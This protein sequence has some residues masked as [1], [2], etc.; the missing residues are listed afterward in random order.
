[1]FGYSTDRTVGYDA[2]RATVYTSAGDPDV[3]KLVERPV[4]LAGPGDVVVR[5]E[6]S[7]VNPTDWKSRRGGSPSGSDWAEVVPHHDGSGIVQALGAGVE[8]LSVGQRVW[9]YEATWQ[10]A[11]GT[12]QEYVALPAGRV[13]PLPAEASF[14][15]GA[16]LGVPALTAH[17]CLTVALD[18]PRQ[19]RPGALDGRTVLVAGGAGAVGHMAVELARWA[20]ARVIATASEP[21]KRHSA[22]LAGADVVIDYRCTDA[23]D[24]I[25]AA[26]PEGVD[27]VVEVAAS[28]N[29][30]LD[31]GVIR[32]GGVV[33]VYGN[34]GGDTLTLELRE[35]MRACV[36]F[37]FVMVFGA[38]PAAKAA[39]VEDVCAAVAAGALRIGEQAGLP[40]HT[41]PLEAIAEAHA[42]VES[43][44]AGK[45]LV[46]V[47][48][49]V[50]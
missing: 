10:R 23:G 48:A 31:L 45:V 19:L 37:Q 27:I 24:Q 16:S 11:G 6:L 46:Q 7:G 13:V 41:F 22:A 20:G 15:L 8:T 35:A 32:R 33:S 12:A 42:A 29:C 17:R 34:N 2:M 38:P 14:E 9:M 47:P 18:G 40:V 50:P 21:E 36:Q 28:P 25:R 4:P 49:L 43:G 26:A 44:L 3:L 1:M 30:R 5:V 39:A